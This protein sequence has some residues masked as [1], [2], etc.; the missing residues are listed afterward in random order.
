MLIG[1]L[2]LFEDYY[3]RVLIGKTEEFY[4]R[5]NEHCLIL[6]RHVEIESAEEKIRG[7]ALRIDHNGALIIECNK[8]REKRVLNGDVSVRL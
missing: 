5:W 2:G 8:G 4:A 1:I 3:E 6:G 7:R